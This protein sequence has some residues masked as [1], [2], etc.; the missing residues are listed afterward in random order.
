V[1]YIAAAVCVFFAQ[2][3]LEKRLQALWEGRFF[4]A[5]R[6]CSV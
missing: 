6:G 1:V 2:H 5:W 3:S 4:I